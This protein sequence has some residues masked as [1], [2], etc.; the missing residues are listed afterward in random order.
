MAKNILWRTLTLKLRR[1]LSYILIAHDFKAR[2]YEDDILEPARARFEL[3]ETLKKSGVFSEEAI[4]RVKFVESLI[5]GYRKDSINTLSVNR[6]ARIFNDLMDLLDKIEIQTLSEKNYLFGVVKAQ[7]DILKREI[8]ERITQII[9][10]EWFPYLIERATE[11]VLSYVHN[12]G[13]ME[14]AL[15][16][17]S[18]VGAKILSKYDFREYA[19]PVQSPDLFELVKDF[20][21]T[22]SYTPFNYEVKVFVARATFKYPNGIGV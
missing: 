10:N 6:D 2:I 13:Q 12:L 21:F 4:Q 5:K 14:K 1:A 20:E 3:S 11:L 19:P 18:E 22:F 7:K 16:F 9:K 15:V 8:K 17:L